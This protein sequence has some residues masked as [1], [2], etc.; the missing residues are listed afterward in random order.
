MRTDSNGIR[1]EANFYPSGKWKLVQVLIFFL[2][3]VFFCSC[4]QD[5]S[6]CDCSASNLVGREMLAKKCENYRGSLTEIA[7]IEWDETV[8]KCDNAQESSYVGVPD[9]AAAA[10]VYS[11]ESPSKVDKINELNTQYD[12]LPEVNDEFSSEDLSL[13]RQ[14][15]QIL[16]AI[17]SLLGQLENSGYR[18]EIPDFDAFRTGI[19]LKYSG[20]KMQEEAVEQMI[21][22]DQ[23]PGH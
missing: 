6:P 16:E 9:P 2:F 4:G 17:L 23:G 7:G 10:E 13:L 22:N 5:L 12:R 15:L 3:G 20:V 21:E 1:G 19:Q 18:N 11:S 8:K 14:K